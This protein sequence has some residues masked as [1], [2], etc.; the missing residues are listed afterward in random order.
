MDA[1]VKFSCLQ[2]QSC[3]LLILFGGQGI[4]L[5]AAVSSKA[6]ALGKV[7]LLWWKKHEILASLL[8]AYFLLKMFP[9]FSPTAILFSELLHLLTIDSTIH[10]SLM[11]DQYSF[12]LFALI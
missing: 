1:L 4:S 6:Y 2:S 11:G 5:L 9:K 3:L 10:C 12:W 8:S 7:L